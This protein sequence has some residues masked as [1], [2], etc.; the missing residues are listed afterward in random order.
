MEGGGGLPTGRIGEAVEDQRL[1][2]YDVL[3]P[4]W[5]DDSIHTPLWVQ[6]WLFDWAPLPLR[7]PTLNPSADSS[8]CC[9]CCWTY[10]QPRRRRPSRHACYAR[11]FIQSSSSSRLLDILHASLQDRNF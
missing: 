7:I 9:S 11:C 1:R 8:R 10:T 4:D 6:R 3:P 5:L 2:T